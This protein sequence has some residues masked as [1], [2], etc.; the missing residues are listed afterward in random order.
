MNSQVLRI[1]GM[2]CASCAQQIEKTVQ[3]LSG[4]ERATV[5]LAS[6]TLFV[7]YNENTVSFATI[8]DAIT[9]VGYGV[10]EKVT[11]QKV[12]IPISGMT[13]AACAKW[14]EK[15]IEKLESVESV[16]V[17]L[18]SEKAT[19]IYN[20]GQVRQSAIRGEIEKVGYKTLEIS[21]VDTADENKE[22]KQ[23]EI[24]TLW[25][26]FSVAALFALPLLYIATVPILP[27]YGINV[28]YPE[29]L[30]PMHHPLIYALMELI[31]VLPIIGVG[32]R[33][34]TIGFK[35]LIHRS[36]NMDSLIATGTSAAVIYSLYNT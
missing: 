23:K 12:A 30:N 29:E 31:L 3:K 11:S 34:Y 24:K 25:T 17:N 27:H 1:T 33:F 2:T 14:V 16:S 26:K 19:V 18:A 7:E 13:C 21:K 22:R 5:N 6:E 28:P 8:K 4:I 32:Y 15:A 20:P 35:A 36:P 10:V 9:K